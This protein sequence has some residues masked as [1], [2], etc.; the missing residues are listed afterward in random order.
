MK[1]LSLLIALLGIVTLVNA[2]TVSA[3]LPAKLQLAIS[4]HD[5]SGQIGTDK[6]TTSFPN[7][8]INSVNTQEV[9]TDAT[10]VNPN[11]PFTQPGHGPAAG[12]PPAPPYTPPPVPSSGSTT[13]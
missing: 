13:Q 4:L 9:G 3:P 10:L 12:W 11:D 6:G 5:N 7:A 2:N 1:K 8:G